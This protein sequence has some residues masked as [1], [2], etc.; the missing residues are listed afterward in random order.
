MCEGGDQTKLPKKVDINGSLTIDGQTPSP[1]MEFTKTLKFPKDKDALEAKVTIADI[2][3]QV[4]V[5]P[6]FVDSSL[7]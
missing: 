7:F 1:L 2:I 4:V 6:F 3:K 5:I